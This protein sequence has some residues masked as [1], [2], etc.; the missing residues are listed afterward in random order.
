MKINSLSVR[1][2]RCIS[3]VKLDGLSPITIL[4]GRNNTGKSTLLEAFALGATAEKG[5]FDALGDDLIETIVARR[6]GWDFLDLMIRI[7]AR[8]SEID[9]KGDNVNGLV[10]VATKAEDL[11]KDIASPILSGV[12]ER[13]DAT[14]RRV[15]EDLAH[16]Y[17]SKTVRERLSRLD[18]ELSKTR[19]GILGKIKG[20]ITYSDRLN[21]K[22]IEY[23]ALIGEQLRESYE[24]I[25]ERYPV[26]FGISELRGNMIRSTRAGLTNVN[27][28]LSPSSAYL[29]ELQ[30][31]LARSGELI[32]LI[33]L[34][35]KRI[36]Y[37]EDLR[38]VQDNFL[39]FIKGLARPVPLELMGDGFRAKL[40]ILAGIATAKGGAILM[41][42]PEIR[43]HPGFMSSI[44]RQIRETASNKET[45][46]II[47]TH[48]AEML[49]FLLHDCAKLITLVR[50]YRSEEAE[51]DYE[52][53]KG[54]EALTEIDKLKADLRGI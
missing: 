33:N 43:L 46:Y 4:V 31:R 11:P 42:E 13:L 44:S 29:K 10:R 3:E 6:G 16:R 18:Y 12:N 37:F 49:D 45:Q 52:V 9:V 35:R 7:G 39:V 19:E 2:Y 32:N 38:E 20:F 41:E 26:G 51:I 30:R 8:F 36:D 24:T 15:Y 5:W 25:A 14:T 54:E 40:A 21:S 50:M 28:L 23:A 22:H 34:M 48:S 1:N 17:D 53:L 27:F 47:S